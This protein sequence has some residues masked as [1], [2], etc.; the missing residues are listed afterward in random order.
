M[1]KGRG[2]AEKQGLP[3][4]NKAVP[5]SWFYCADDHGMPY[6]NRIKH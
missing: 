5:G 1:M 6:K 2:L 3:A 4:G